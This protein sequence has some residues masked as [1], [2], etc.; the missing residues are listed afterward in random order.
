L[1]EQNYLNLLAEEKALLGLPDK[2]RELIH[3]EQ[4]LLDLLDEAHTQHEEYIVAFP[5]HFP[6]G[7]LNA[8][9]PRLDTSAY[10]RTTVSPGTED[11]DPQ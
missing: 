9:R 10:R 5:Q 7:D 11:A 3:D 6:E 8:D 1:R 4:G 2:S